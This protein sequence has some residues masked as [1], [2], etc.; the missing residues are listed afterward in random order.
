LGVVAG[1]PSVDALGMAR[2][3][4]QDGQAAVELVA[5]LPLLMLVAT[6][7]WQLVVAGQA[8]W[9]AGSAAREAARARALGDDP[10]LAARHVLPARL[11]SGVVV[12]DD[13]DGV[14]LR[15]A[16]P[17]VVPGLRVG[18]VRVRARMEPQS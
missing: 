18:T 9:L 1:R 2:A 4:D 6:L 11:R 5:L 15:L 7:L 16:V 12:R 13:H 3:R 10:A 14:T 8:W 17:G